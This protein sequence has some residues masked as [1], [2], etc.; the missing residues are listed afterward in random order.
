MV[1]NQPASGE[2]P[3]WPKKSPALRVLVVDDEPLIRWSVSETLA[4]AGH[5]VVECGD[6]YCARAAVRDAA[7][8]F[9]VIV[10]DL[11]MPD[12]EDLSLLTSLRKIAPKTEVIL[13]TAY[14]TPEIVGA[15]LDLGAFRVLNKPF[16][17]F[18]LAQLVA[19]AGAHA[20]TP[21][22]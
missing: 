19:A 8:P 11:R 3:Q 12:S 22:A 14:G 16:E 21:D 18:D 20:T 4:D 10:L 17:L 5:H 7:R 6:G 1:M 9:D 15:A 13:M 2:I